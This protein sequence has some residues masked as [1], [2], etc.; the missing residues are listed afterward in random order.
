MRSLVW[1]GLERGAVRRVEVSADGG[2]TWKD[3]KLQE[4]IHRKAYTRF[5]FDWNW[6]GDT[7]RCSSRDARTN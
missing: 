2:R 7:A 1:L 3:A 5:R 6:N 4:P